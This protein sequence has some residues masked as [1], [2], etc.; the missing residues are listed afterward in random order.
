MQKAILFHARPAITQMSL[1]SLD[2]YPLQGGTTLSALEA[3]PT[4]LSKTNFSVAL[5]DEMTR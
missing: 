1:N 4:L 5:G 3:D 2:L